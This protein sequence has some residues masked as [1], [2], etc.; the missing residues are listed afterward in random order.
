MAL[1]SSSKDDDLGE[2]VFTKAACD[3]LGFESL[4]LTAA[5]LVEK[6]V[7]SIFFVRFWDL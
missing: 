3:F 2:C 7:S 6:I 1:L 5:S 4:D